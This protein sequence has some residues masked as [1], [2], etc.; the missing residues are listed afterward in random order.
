MATQA[1][2]MS[3][4]K[5]NEMVERNEDQIT[6]TEENFGDLLIEGLQEALTIRRGDKEPAR[7]IRRAVTLREAVVEPPRAFDAES[8]QRIR[9]RMGLSQAVCS[10]E[11]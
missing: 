8:I 2:D 4:E 6:V 5:E 3:V 11:C 9:E 7:R 10:H 1:K